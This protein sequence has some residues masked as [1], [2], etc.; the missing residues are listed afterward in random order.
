MELD[1]GAAVSVLSEATYKAVWNVENL[2]PLQP[3][4]VHLH[5]YTGD[6]IPV[7]GMMHVSVQHNQQARQLPLLIVKGDGPTLLARDWLTQLRLDIDWSSVYN[8]Q[9]QHTV[10]QLLHKHSPVY[11]DELGTAKGVTVTLHVDPAVQPKFYKARP[12]HHLPKLKPLLLPHLQQMFHN[13]K[14]S[15]VL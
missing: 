4:Q 11:A 10:S 14:P 2:P 8:V 12:D 3:S 7:L 1:T 6:T 13:L 5:M 15:W 9:T